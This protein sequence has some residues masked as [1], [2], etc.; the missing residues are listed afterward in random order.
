[1]LSILLAAGIISGIS[2][3][4]A[5]LL[6]VAERYIANYGECS[7]TINDEKQLT[8]QGG[9]PLLE[10]LAENKI[11]I[12]SACGGR[13][14]CAYCKVKILEGGGPVAPTE[15]PL[16][17]PDERASNVRISCQVKVR[18]NLKIEIPEELFNVREH[19]GRVTRIRDLT[20]D[21]KELRIELIEPDTIAFMPGQ[22][23]Q[24]VAP[25]YGKNPEPVYRA[26]SLSNPGSDNHAVE[27]IVRLV[28]GGIC[29][30]WVFEH[31]KEG[32]EV[33]L[34]GPYGEFRLSDTDKEM[35]WIAGGSGMAPFWS[36]ARHM[37]EN[38]SQRKCTYLFGAL[39]KR[40][41]FLLDEWREIEAKLP[42]FTF[43]PA[44]SK[45]E[46]DDNWDGE[47]GLITE[48]AAKHIA[49]SSEAEAY[50]CGS[51]GMIG[52]ACKVLIEKGISHDR[53]FYDSFT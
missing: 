21:M 53:H 24:L 47:T 14:T 13:G 12:P 40:D 52:A 43:V 2:A 25:A 37:A 10:S 45:P 51:G 34:N 31:L 5:A 32:D 6:V 16:L 41:L 33:M 11:F 35:I 19:R 46:P 28:P 7:I 26:Y 17:E 48:V 22:Y 50:L 29:T 15:L 49:D 39:S 9:R 42:N 30:T 38:N 18:E 4:L 20:H 23:V 3:V 36:I 1:M 44:L 27:L 8:V